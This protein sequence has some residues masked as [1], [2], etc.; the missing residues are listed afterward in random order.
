MFKKIARETERVLDQ[1]LDLANKVTDKALGNSMG[2]S[3]SIGGSISSGPN[4]G[5]QIYLQPPSGPSGG[6]GIGNDGKAHIFSDGIAVAP[7]ESRLDFE[8][9]AAHAAPFVPGST[10]SSTELPIGNDLPQLPLP[11]YIDGVSGFDTDSRLNTFERLGPNTGSSNPILL[12]PQSASEFTPWTELLTPQDDPTRSLHDF[13]RNPIN[14]AWQ[15]QESNTLNRL[16][17]AAGRAASIGHT[18]IKP[19]IDAISLAAAGQQLGSQLAYTGQF[20][21]LPPP[22]IPRAINEQA[23]CPAPAS[24]LTSFWDAYRANFQSKLDEADQHGRRGSYF[25]AGYTSGTAWGDVAMD[26]AAVA[27]LAYGAYRYG[28]TL[29]RT[30]AKKAGDGTTWLFGKYGSNKPHFELFRRLNSKSLNELAQPIDSALLSKLG[31]KGWKIDIAKPGTED[32]KYLTMINADA[33]FNTGVPKHILIKEGAPKSA[34]LEEFLHGTQNQLGLL[35]LA[36]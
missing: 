27:T 30:A 32:W 31:A 11:Q 24:G 34:L 7:I 9:I 33:S 2:G 25:M 10:G 17:F 26:A 3:G 14:N 13:M 4:G 36:T 16:E 15:P 5:V 35:E 21:E 28:P 6:V 22:S 1:A 20:P 12:V 29:L 8:S 18:L 19:V 23:T